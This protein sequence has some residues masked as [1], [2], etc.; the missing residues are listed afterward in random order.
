[1]LRWVFQLVVLA[2]VAGRG[3]DPGR[4]RP[5]N[6]ERLGIPTGY[7]YLDNPAQF[8]DPDSDF[9]QTQPVRDAILVGLGNTIRVSVLGIVRPRILG[10]SIGVARL[11]GNLLVRTLAG[12]STSRPSATSRCC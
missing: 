10:T 4:Q 5:R 8:P 11:S 3:V 9:R 6:S 12:V 1:M 2:V 7:G